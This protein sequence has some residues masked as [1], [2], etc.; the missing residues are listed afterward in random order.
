MGGSNLYPEERATIN[1]ITSHSGGAI[2][3]KTP[4]AKPIKASSIM[5][6]FFMFFPHG[7][8]VDCSE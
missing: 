8:Q 4:K 7:L 6:A 3:E 2:N 1:K 5:F